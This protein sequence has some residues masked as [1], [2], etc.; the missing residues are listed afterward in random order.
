[1]LTMS[2][3]QHLN[4]MWRLEAAQILMWALRLLPEV[5]APDTQSDIDLSKLEILNHPSSFLSSACCGP[6]SEIYLVR[7][8]WL[9]FGIGAAVPSNSS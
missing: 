1:M 2:L 9:S 7:E 8:I 3:Q 4:A 5:P 6:Q